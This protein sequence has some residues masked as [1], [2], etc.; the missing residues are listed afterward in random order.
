M[1][2]EAKMG[3]YQQKPVMPK[4]SNPNETDAAK[5]KWDAVAAT[6]VSSARAAKVGAVTGQDPVGQP[7]GQVE[8]GKVVDP[9]LGSNTGLNI[10]QALS[11]FFTELPTEMKE[12]YLR[13]AVLFM[14]E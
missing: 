6:M 14:Q 2:P 10:E 7:A 5:E 12:E 11:A 13:K 8:S 1:G 4:R 3:K 9:E